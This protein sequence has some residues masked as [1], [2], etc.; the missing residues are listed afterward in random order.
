MHCTLLLLLGV[1]LWL[2]RASTEDELF[3]F[4]F[5]SSSFSS[6]CCSF[7]LRSKRVAATTLTCYRC[8]KCHNSF[9]L[10]PQHQPPSAGARV[11]EIK[12]LL[13]LVLV[14]VCLGKL[15]KETTK[16]RKK[17]RR[18]TEREREGEIDRESLVLWFWFYRRRGVGGLE[19]LGILEF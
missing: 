12:R 16:E 4:S 8:Y 17:E 15:E 14:C 6:S 13:T 19:V 10:P 1:F 3:S 18:D 2:L 5:F 9:F 7:P 11:V